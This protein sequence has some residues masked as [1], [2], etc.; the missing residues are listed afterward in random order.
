MAPRC[1]CGK[2]GCVVHPHESIEGIGSP[3]RPT[4][5]KSGFVLR[6]WKDQT[7]RV[8]SFT[9]LGCA[10]KLINRRWFAIHAAPTD[11]ATGWP[12]RQDRGTVESTG[13]SSHR[14]LNSMEERTRRD[15]PIVLTRGTPDAG[16]AG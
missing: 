12:M 5:E 10:E 15:T 7:P 8:W 13:K 1:Y 9:A 16:H 2:E 14:V 11:G 4:G 6:R 3:V